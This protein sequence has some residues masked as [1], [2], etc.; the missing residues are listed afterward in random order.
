VKV[1]RRGFPII[2]RDTITVGGVVFTADD[3]GGAA[4]SDDTPLVESGA[5]DAGVSSEA[6]RSDH[7]HPEFDSG[8]IWR[9]LM[10][11]DPDDDHWYVVVAEDG[12]AVMVEG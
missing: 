6:A 9:P 1:T 2:P 12:T 10:A 4:L 3:L 11:F 8:V 7:V 5:G